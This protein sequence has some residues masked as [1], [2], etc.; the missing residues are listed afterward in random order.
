MSRQAAVALAGGGPLIG[1]SRELATISAVRTRGSAGVVVHAPAG[2][3]KSR[4]AR[5]ALAAAVDD[6]ARTAW[7]HDRPAA[8]RPIQ[9]PG[10]S[11]RGHVCGDHDAGGYVRDL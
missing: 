11:V 8:S 10:L 4:L 5:A 1:R 9:Q 3:G 7:I 2:V 6:G